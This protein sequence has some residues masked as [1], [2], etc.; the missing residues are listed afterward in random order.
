MIPPKIANL[1]EWGPFQLDALG[2]LTIF[3]AKEMNTAVGNLVQSSVTEWLPILGSYTVANDDIIKPEPGYVL[4]NITD[5][6]M[7]TD[8]SAWF[9]RW[10]STF[11]LTYTA[12]TIRLRVENQQLPIVRQAISITIGLSVIGFLFS[13]AIVTA[14]A[15]GIANVAS[16][17][18]SVISRQFIV[19]CLR[20]SIDHTIQSLKDD[21]GQDVKV[22]MTLPDG[23]A[24]TI[25]GPRMIVVTCLLTE[26]QP[27]HPQSYYVMRMASWAAFGAHA[28]TLGMSDLFNQILTVVILLL[29]TYLTATHVGGYREAIGTRLCLDVDM[30]DPDLP[31]GAAYSRLKMSPTEEDCMVHWSMMPQ[32]SNVWWWDRYKQQYLS[33]QATSVTKE[34]EGNPRIRK[35]GSHT[36]QNV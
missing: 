7:A 9:T 2:L 27:I 16:M 20:S 24:V 22:F 10:I 11:P 14:D 12:T 30:G 26:A 36:S 13:M 32:R 18:V 31:R 1:S 29:A 15:W 3:G 21:P 33:N 8:V 6:I 34:M 4:Y 35:S 19:T 25:L 23:K 17:A 28:I 5:G